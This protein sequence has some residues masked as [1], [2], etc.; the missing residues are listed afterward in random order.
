LSDSFSQPINPR[1]NAKMISLTW[2]FIVLG[3]IVK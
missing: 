1:T 3:L 2:V